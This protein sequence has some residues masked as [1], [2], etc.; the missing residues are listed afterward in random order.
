MKLFL[1]DVD[2]TL[3]QSRGNGYN[4]LSTALIELYS[5]NS[6]LK[7]ISLAG[8]T[9]RFIFESVVLPYIPENASPEVKEAK[10]QQLFDTYLVKLQVLVQDSYDTKT[11]ITSELL[12]GVHDVLERI[13]N[14]RDYS[15]GLLTGNIG[16]GAS[17]K[18]GALYKR[19][20]IHAFGKYHKDRNKL[21]DIALEHFS[22]LYGNLPEEV[23]II[24]DTPYDIEV[25]RSCNRCKATAIAVA[26]GKYNI[27]DLSKADIILPSLTQWPV[28]RY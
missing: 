21:L 9:D 4:A 7:S 5:D 15:L 26:T 8:R 20:L 22:E 2:G 28:D 14:N 3:I 13:E 6:T 12:P 27:N 25:A 10:V 16:E 23:I 24:G 11:G 19:F 1:F 18:L 17:L